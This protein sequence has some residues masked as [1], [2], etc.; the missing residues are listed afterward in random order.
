MP[1][2]PVFGQCSDRHVSDIL[3]VDDRFRDVAAGHRQHAGQDRIA[4][5]AFGEVLGEPGG[6]NEREVDP[7]VAHDLLT[8][9]GMVLA[10]SRQEDKML[11]AHV[12]CRLDEG[13]ELLDRAGEGE[14][15]EVGDVGCADTA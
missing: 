4:Q 14:I 11:D 10:P 5:I 6:S 1:R 13:L 3:D 8:Q 15:G 12:F 7:G 2:W 9:P